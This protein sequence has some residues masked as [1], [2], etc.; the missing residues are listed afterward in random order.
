MNRILAPTCLV[1]TSLSLT[2]PAYAADRYV[3][4][5]DTKRVCN[6]EGCKDVEILGDDYRIID[7]RAGT[8]F[9]GKDQFRL[10]GAEV[11]GAFEIFKVGGAFFMKMVSIDEFLSRLKRGQFIEVR[12][13]FLSVI[14]SYGVYKF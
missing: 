3:G 4:Q 12:D 2:F 8:Y 6:D 10:E 1:L 7:K 9:I 5:V 13:L 11:S 14:T